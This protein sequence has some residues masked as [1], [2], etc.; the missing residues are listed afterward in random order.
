MPV[1]RN[2]L[3]L[4]KRAVKQALRQLSQPWLTR[5]RIV[6]D[7]GA[8]GVRRGGILL[9]H[10]SLSAL[11]YVVGGG[12]AV[13]RALTEG[14]GPEGTL[15]MPAHSWEL[16]EAGC[17]T[18]DVRSTASC[19]GTIPELFRRMPGVARS[20]HPTH[21]VAARGPLAPWLVEGH[22]H[23]ESPCGPETPYAKILDRDGQILFLGISLESNT[24]FHTI[25]A[26]AGFPSLLCREPD[27]FTIIDASGACRS[28]AFYQQRRGVARRYAELEEPL[29][30]ERIVRRGLV[31]RAPTLLI[32][33]AAFLEFM[34]AIL[35]DDP[36]YLMAHPVSDVAPRDSGQCSVVSGQRRSP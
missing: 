18:F 28:R 14:I 34:T 5:R 31:G 26:I 30:G 24:A 23:C 21:S 16:M 6:A 12:P 33:G 19:V 20:L 29:V 35:H 2:F 15:V 13:V 8:L 3:R 25:E 32:A 9:V 36:T 27:T 7:L 11:G 1:S 22:E 17:R 10:S 4:A